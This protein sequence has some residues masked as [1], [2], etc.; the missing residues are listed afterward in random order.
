M[1]SRDP[2]YEQFSQLHFQKPPKQNGRLMGASP[3]LVSSNKAANEARLGPLLQQHRDLI[4]RMISPGSMRDMPDRP[5]YPTGG[6]MPVAVQ[7]MQLNVDL[8]PDTSGRLTLLLTG[9]VDAPLIQ[10]FRDANGD[11]ISAKAI[12]FEVYNQ[13]VDYLRTNRIYGYRSVAQSVTVENTSKIVEIQGQVEAALVRP[14]YD[15][16]R[17]KDI[18]TGKEQRVWTI[19]RPPLDNRAIAASQQTYYSGRAT[20]GLYMVNRLLDVFNP[21]KYRDDDEHKLSY[22]EYTVADMDHFNMTVAATNGTLLAI[23][24]DDYTGL[25]V[26]KWASDLVDPY[27]VGAFGANGFEKHV[28]VNQPTNMQLC[29]GYFS[30]L[31][32][33]N[34]FRVKLVMDVEFLVKPGSFFWTFARPMPPLNIQCVLAYA[35]CAYAAAN[36]GPASANAFADFLKSVSSI[37]DKV[38]PVAGT[39]LQAVDDPRVKAAGVA[40]GTIANVKKALQDNSQQQ[41]QLQQQVTQVAQQVKAVKASVAP[42]AT[43]QRRKGNR[44]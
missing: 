37:F 30:G 25:P 40:L 15:F 19:D 20:D 4:S 6:Q 9:F 43:N 32:Q 28:A 1:S 42:P 2:I 34:T 11:V 33:A 38:A 31:D 23:A 14:N 36:C 3:L 17:V 39:I 16:K 13:Q 21:W 44:Q 27:D 35:A 18:A 5:I 29:V 12:Q 8:K 26:E 10:V 22:S 41:K 7:Q 24:N